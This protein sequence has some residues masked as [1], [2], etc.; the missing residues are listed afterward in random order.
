MKDPNEYGKDIHDLLR[1]LKKILKSQKQGP[2][3]LSSVIGDKNVNLNLCFFTF[4]P[5]TE[6]ELEEFESELGQY[7]EDGG[8]PVAKELKFEITKKDLDFLKQHGLKF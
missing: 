8:V 2:V 5:L 4:L 3:D 1:I 7:L 6:E